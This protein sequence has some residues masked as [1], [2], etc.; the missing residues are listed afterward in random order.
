MKGYVFTYGVDGFGADVAPAYEEGCYLD[1]DKAFAHL[2]ELNERA[3]QDCDHTF[4]EK[5]YG[6]DYYPESDIALRQA[7]LKKDWK[8]YDA[9]MDKHILTDIAA[10]CKRILEYDEPPFHMYKMEEIEVNK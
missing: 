3:L 2:C 6:E 8:R 7:E 1:Y 10:I 9:E 5:G 4:Y